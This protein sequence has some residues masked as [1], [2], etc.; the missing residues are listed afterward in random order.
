MGKLLSAAAAAAFA[1]SF[2]GIVG[3]GTPASGGGS[4]PSSHDGDYSLGELSVGTPQALPACNSANAGL[5][6]YV[7]STQTL[8]SC[9][10]GSWVAIALP[11]R[12]ARGLRRATRDRPDP[13]GRRAPRATQ[14]RKEP[15]ARPG[16]KA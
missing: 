5:V 10:S 9:I 11:A 12:A 1:L 16:R 15:P 3:C 14:A 7:R 13:R 2:A 8:E 4:Q 6:A